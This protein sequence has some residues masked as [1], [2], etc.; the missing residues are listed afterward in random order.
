MSTFRTAL[1]A[2]E[3]FLEADFTD[4]KIKKAGNLDFESFKTKYS[5]SDKIICLSLKGGDPLDRFGDGTADLL[6]EGMT[7]FMVTKLNNESDAVHEG[8][9]LVALLAGAFDFSDEVFGS[10]TL[11]LE[12]WNL[13]DDELGIIFEINVGVN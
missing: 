8:N 12:S 10:R 6:K 4:Y 9:R 2:L 13:I 3:S 11:Y 5:L 1:D 7:M